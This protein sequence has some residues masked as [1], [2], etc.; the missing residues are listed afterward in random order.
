MLAVA[1]GDVKYAMTD[2]LFWLSFLH[3]HCKIRQS[4]TILL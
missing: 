2:A 1:K 3:N 4:K